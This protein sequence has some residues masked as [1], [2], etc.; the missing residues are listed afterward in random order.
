MIARKERILN[1]AMEVQ[2]N[3]YDPSSTA[4]LLLEFEHYMS[5]GCKAALAG[6]WRWDSWGD[7]VTITYDEPHKVFLG[8]V[9]S[10]MVTCCITNSKK[11]PGICVGYDKSLSTAI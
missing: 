5:D 6:D 11:R 2:L 8:D 1:L 7:I 4:A 3:D 10:W 9:C